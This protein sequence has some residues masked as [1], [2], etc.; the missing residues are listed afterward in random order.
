MSEST[1]PASFFRA[2]DEA[3][4]FSNPAASEAAFRAM[5]EE[6]DVA[7][8]PAARAIVLSQVAR[9][10]GLQQRFDAARATLDL[11]DAALA[12]P[13]AALAVG[14]AAS[15]AP[16]HAADAAR[17]TAVARVRILLERG[18]VANSS[19]D[20]VASR[21]FFVAAWEAARA[22]GLEGLAIDAAHML[23]IA[24]EPDQAL[25]WNRLALDLAEAATDPAARRWIG[26]LLNNIGWTL[27]DCGEHADA[28]AMFERDVVHRGTL[29][30]LPQQRIARWSRAKMLRLLGRVVEALAEQE[31]L[32]AEHAAA[33][34]PDPYVREELGECLLVLDRAPDA[35]PHFAAA[36]AILKD[37][38]WLRR[39]EPARLERLARLGGCG[40]SSPD[41][42]SR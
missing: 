2:V 20:R 12:S 11:A 13:D 21:P 36:H 22:V 18:R 27:A 30:Q 19:G 8:H 25:R 15:P 31:R 37:D 28:L 24:E 33:G 14:A 10:Q 5:T 40:A 16:D 38:P 6:P 26:P 29:G 7:A 41:A 23:G 39:D 1:L 9:A 34:T 17:P 35:A 32:L 4:D 42:S 3:W